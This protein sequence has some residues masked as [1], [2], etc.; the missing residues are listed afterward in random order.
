MEGVV[1]GEGAGGIVANVADDW[2]DICAKDELG[3]IQESS[4]KVEGREMIEASHQHPRSNF[5]V[6]ILSPPQ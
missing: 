2:L 1:V 5:R 6:L 4:R 3:R